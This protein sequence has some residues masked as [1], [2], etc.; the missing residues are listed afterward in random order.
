LAASERSIRLR[1][2]NYVCVAMAFP[3]GSCVICCGNS[4]AEDYPEGLELYE[5][6]AVAVFILI[7]LLQIN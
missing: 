4:G 6:Q 3:F 7:I 5:A 2:P 1:V